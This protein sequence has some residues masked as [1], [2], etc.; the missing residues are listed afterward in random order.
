M[1]LINQ[2]L[3]EKL[4][5]ND[6]KCNQ[7]SLQMDSIFTIKLDNLNSLWDTIALFNK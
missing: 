5:E 4:K 2:N 7:L 1:I 6:Y 3:S